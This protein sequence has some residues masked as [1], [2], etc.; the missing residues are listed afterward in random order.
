MK[1]EHRYTLYFLSLG[2]IVVV[3]DRLAKSWVLV[4]VPFGRSMP[5]V[6]KFLYVTHVHNTGG[7]WGLF[8]NLSP[9]FVVMGLLVPILI[10]V[11]YKKLMEKGLGWV[12]AA[13]LILGGALG[14]LYDRVFYHHVVDFLDVKYNG[15][16]IWPI[17]NVADIAISVGIGIL[18]ICL[19]R[20]PPQ[21]KEQEEELK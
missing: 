18:F 14:N 10:L 8:S 19:L 1:K 11:F 17:F 21:E 15:G 3:L 7:A 20:E 12:I 4:T 5:L 9:L 16:S 6:G 2:I 13:A